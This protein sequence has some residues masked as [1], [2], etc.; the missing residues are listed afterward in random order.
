MKK[1]G[2]LLLI[3]FTFI[4]FAPMLID[5]PGYISIAMGGMIYEL[6]MYTAMFW[7]LFV[8][9]ILILLFILLRGGFRFSLGT[10]NKLAFASK[11][12]GVKDFEKAVAAYI[13]EDYVQAEH[14]FA[15][16]A[17]P[18]QQQRVGYLLASSAAS[19]QAL[20]S[21]TQHY[22]G[23]LDSIGNNV[24]NGNLESVLVTIKLYIEQGDSE[25]ARALI[26]EHHKFIGHDARLLSLDIDLMLIEKRFIAAV[27]SLV[28]ARKQK[29]ITEKTIK[30]WE[31][32][33]FYGAFNQLVLEKNAEELS[34]YW[35]N[36]SSKVKQREVVVMAYCKVLAEQSIIQPLNKILLPVVKKGTDKTFLQQMRSLPLR[37]ADELIAVVQKHLQKD[38]QNGTWLSC[39]AHLA[40]SSKQWDMAEKAFNSL[41]NLGEIQY[42]NVD[43]IAF[44]KVLQQRQQFEKAAQ[45]YAKL[46]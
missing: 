23:L 30:K 33:A 17:E 12:R 22:L 1:L 45:V 41:V 8:F 9:L 16:S 21:N 10:W 40:V 25:K 5:D 13:L 29:T 38:P 3:F 37:A 4:A 32:T 20:R 6:T 26:D 14:L 42:D 43:L 2:V 46:H 34:R 27:E 15:K 39:L 31:E 36:L 18:A 19:K 35:N 24:K 28:L 7:I 44:A 11:R